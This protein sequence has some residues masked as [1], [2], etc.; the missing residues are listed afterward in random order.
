MSRLPAGQEIV[1]FRQTE[2][3]SVI[4]LSMSDAMRI[5]SSRDLAFRILSFIFYRNKMSHINWTVRIWISRL[6]IGR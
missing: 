4:Y 3:I 2:T 5:L 1:F 6:G